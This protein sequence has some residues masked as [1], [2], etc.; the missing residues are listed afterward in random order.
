LQFHRNIL[1]LTQLE[2]TNLQIDQWWNLWITGRKK[3]IKLETPTRVWSV[4]RA[5]TMKY[6]NHSIY[7]TVKT[8]Y[9]TFSTIYI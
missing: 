4:F 9:Y 8:I 7:Y 1:T 2:C 3:Y 6:N 5:G